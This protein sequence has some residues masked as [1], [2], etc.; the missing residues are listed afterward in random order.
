MTVR[1]EYPNFRN[2]LAV[3]KALVDFTATYARLSNPVT[4]T[5]PSSFE[6]SVCRTDPVNRE[7]LQESLASLETGLAGEVTGGRASNYQIG[8]W[9][10]QL[11][12]M[13]A[14]AAMLK[15]TPEAE[16]ANL[17]RGAIQA[18]AVLLRLLRLVAVA[19]EP[20]TKLIR[21]GKRR[22]YT[23]GRVARPKNTMLLPV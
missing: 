1:K 8:V 21:P 11:A 18:M 7:R 17:W 4:A 12:T 20:S 16:R 23:A 6:H 15:S 14:K 5:E 2:L 9:Y 3:S 10:N 22:C 19:V 13:Y